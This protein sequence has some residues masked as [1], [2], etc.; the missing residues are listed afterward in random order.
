MIVW[1]VFIGSLFSLALIISKVIDV[2]KNINQLTED[3]KHTEQFLNA[4]EIFVRDPLDY[5]DVDNDGIDD[6]MEK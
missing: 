1:V 5:K 3:E 6:I 4:K 2:A